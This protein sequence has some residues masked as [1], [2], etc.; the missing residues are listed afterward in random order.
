[1][2]KEITILFTAITLLTGCQQSKQPQ[3]SNKIEEKRNVVKEEFTASFALKKEL[4]TF[5]KEWEGTKYKAG[6]TTKKGIDSSALT[7]RLYIDKFSTK[8]PRKA[9]QQAKLGIQIRKEN[10]E[11]GDIVILKRKDELF[12]GVYLGN[13]EFIHSSFKGVLIND[14]TKKPY[15]SIYYDARRVF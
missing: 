15:S 14:I 11:I 1:M 9:Y 4:L 10:L 5:Y 7:Q 8:I 13:N 2:K 12:T 3:V 6:G